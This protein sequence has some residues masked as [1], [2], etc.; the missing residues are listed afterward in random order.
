MNLWSSWQKMA[1]FHVFTYL[2]F[3]FGVIN[4]F[5]II[6]DVFSKSNLSKEMYCILRNT[7]NNLQTMLSEVCSG[8]PFLNYHMYKLTSSICLQL[9]CVIFRADGLS[10]T[11]WKTKSCL[12]SIIYTYPSLS[13][14]TV[15]VERS[16]DASL[17]WHYCRSTCY[18][19]LQWLCMLRQSF[20]ISNSLCKL[21]RIQ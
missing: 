7:S 3:L 14:D 21:Y 5:T 12:N 19:L 17:L 13:V 9:I 20:V 18:V 1:C 11:E 2:Q 8:N 4:S 10:L 16:Y 15:T 6:I